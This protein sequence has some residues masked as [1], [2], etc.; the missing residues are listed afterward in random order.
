[1]PCHVRVMRYLPALIAPVLVAAVAYGLD[2]PKMLGAHPW[3]SGNVIAIGLPV[4][5][6]LALALN[7]TGLAAAWRVGA[8]GLAMLGA[9]AFA[10]VGKARFAASYAED[11]LAGQ[12]WFFGW[13]ATCAFAAALIASTLLRSRSES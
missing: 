13:I 12:M 5:L 10:S 6:A 9:F 11:A 3:W 8:M 1:M 4:G 2:L 7:W